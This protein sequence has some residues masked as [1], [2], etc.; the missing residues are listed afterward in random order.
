[1]FVWPLALSIRDFRSSAGFGSRRF[2]TLCQRELDTQKSAQHG[3]GIIAPQSSVTR[4]NVLGH[5]HDPTGDTGIAGEFKFP[6]APEFLSCWRPNSIGLV[7]I[8]TTEFFFVTVVMLAG[9]K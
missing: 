4:N 5:A 3:D 7:L 2:S 8:V 9:V 6:T 1:M